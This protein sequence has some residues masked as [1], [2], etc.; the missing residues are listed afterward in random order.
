MA[1]VS[2]PVSP[3]S[4]NFSA[5][6]SGQPPCIVYVPVGSNSAPFPV[7]VFLDDIFVTAPTAPISVG[8]FTLGPTLPTDPQP[9][10]PWKVTLS[11]TGDAWSFDASPIRSALHDAFLEFCV[12]VE[13]AAGTAG[14]QV[15]K[16][17]RLRLLQQY[18]AQALP[19]TF[20]ETLFYRYG[21]DPA[22]RCVDL[23]PGM[24]L[25]VA[26]QAHQAL[27]PQQN[28]LNG[29]VGTGQSTIEVGVTPGS[30][31]LALGTFLPLLQAMSVAPNTGGAGGDLD[32]QGQSYAYPYFRLI[33]PANLPSSD[34]VGFTGIQ[35][36]PTLI[37]APTF[38]GLLAAT[39]SYVQSGTVG[40][41]AVA[42]FF[43]GRA[44]VAPEIPIFLQ[45][46]RQ[47]IPLGTTVRGLLT[48]VAA[49]PWFDTG[50][51]TMP[52]QFYT[53]QRTNLLG[54]TA[55]PTWQ[56]QPPNATT[57]PAISFSTQP[58][59]YAC[60]GPALDSFDLPVLGGD[61]LSLPLQAS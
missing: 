31:D 33:Y 48:G 7:T 36:N 35:Q 44:S 12:A 22:A 3:S 43:R 28:P 6:I 30:A 42:A 46:E 26:F 14:A 53:R 41:G 29:F 13:N 10:L 25:R 1:T 39:A 27:D 54:K 56:F 21:L 19:Q 34:G 17:G 32:L 49:V 37:G 55:P 24:R 4:Y 50:T 38:A 60:Y 40:A 9:K 45:G 23:L 5:P 18:L 16:P 2:W 57:T 8:P 51:V 15:L 47:Y 11:A 58:G 52:T 20:T 61:N 59:G